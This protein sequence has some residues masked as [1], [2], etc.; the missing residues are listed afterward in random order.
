MDTWCA[1]D[2]RLRRRQVIGFACNASHTRASFFRDQPASGY[3]PGIQRHLTKPFKTTG[4]DVT[5]IERRR[6]QPAHALRELAKF[7]EVIEVILW[8]I[9][10]I[11]RETCHE[12]A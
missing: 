11:V 3:I 10:G 7:Y 5:E 6:T 12:Q 8:C 9:P 4:G 2:H 1:G